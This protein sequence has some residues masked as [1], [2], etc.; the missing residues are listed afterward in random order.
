MN[1]KPYPL[2]QLDACADKQVLPCIAG[3]ASRIFQRRESKPD[4]QKEWSVQ[5]IELTQNGTTVKVKIWDHPE[6][7]RSNEG[8]P[9][10]I[11]ASDGKGLTGIFVL[12]DDYDG[13]ITRMIRL[14][15]SA[16]ISFETE[17]SSAPPRHDPPPAETRQEAPQTKTAAAPTPIV[18]AKRELMKLANLHLLSTMVVEKVLAPEYKKITGREMPEDR[19]GASISSLIIAGEKRGLHLNLPTRPMREGEA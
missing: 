6:I 19:R 17:Q 2:S 13:K 3:T 5:D 18:E 15:A 4:A 8:K 1:A 14:T 16:E 9:V 11:T 12:D 10:T 7:A